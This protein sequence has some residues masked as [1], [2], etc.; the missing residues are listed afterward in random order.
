MVNVKGPD[1]LRLVALSLGFIEPGVRE[2]RHLYFVYLDFRRPQQLA[3][4]FEVPEIQIRIAPVLHGIYPE[5][6]L[7]IP[8]LDLD[9]VGDRLDPRLASAASPTRSF[10]FRRVIAHRCD[11]L[12]AKMAVDYCFAWIAEENRE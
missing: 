1:R 9:D 10:P 8:I 4:N 6:E 11:V 7:P 5:A 3:L 12:P 2:E